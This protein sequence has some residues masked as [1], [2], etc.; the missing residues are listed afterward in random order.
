MSVNQIPSIGRIVRY[1]MA[2]NDQTWRQQREHAAII[3]SVNDVTWPSSMTVDLTVFFGGPG[4][5]A[6]SE[7]TVSKLNVP[8]IAKAGEARWSWPPGVQAP[9]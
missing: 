4:T 7:S 5:S 2:D 3:T 1:H 8:L 9:R 6:H